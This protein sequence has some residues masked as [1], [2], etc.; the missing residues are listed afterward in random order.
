VVFSGD[1]H[2]LNGV[3]RFYGHTWEAIQQRT[4]LRAEKPT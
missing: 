1:V 4:K 3:E 2:I